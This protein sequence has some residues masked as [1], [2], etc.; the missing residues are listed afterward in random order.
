MPDDPDPPLLPGTIADDDIEPGPT[1][2]KDGVEQKERSSCAEQ[3]EHDAFPKQEVGATEN[4]R[5]LV[6]AP[7]RRLSSSR[8]SFMIIQ[9]RSGLS[10]TTPTSPKSPK[11][12][13]LDFDPYLDL[14]SDTES[15][16]GWWT[17]LKRRL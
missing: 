15:D 7:D 12:D 1:L 11:V 3:K 10:P 14:W 8:S 9:N 5:P 6:S 2:L 16:R 4:P 17:K 13:R